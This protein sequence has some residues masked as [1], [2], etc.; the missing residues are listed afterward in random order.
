MGVLLKIKLG[1]A[2][3]KQGFGS[4]VGSRSVSR[5]NSIVVNNGNTVAEELTKQ[6]KRVHQIR[7]A[8]RKR[9]K[10]DQSHAKLGILFLMLFPLF[11]LVFNVIYW[12]TFL[13]SPCR[14]DESSCDDGMHSNT[15]GVGGVQGSDNPASSSIS[16]V[17]DLHSTPSII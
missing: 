12:T 1:A 11:F 17:E 10:E 4:V 3:K 5:E 8:T 9:Q 16:P 15:I 13:Y 2:R 6:E 14:N 7:C